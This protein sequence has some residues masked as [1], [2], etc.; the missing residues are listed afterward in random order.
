M[1]ES[2][3]D[4]PGRDTLYAIADYFNVSVDYILHGGDAT[5]QPPRTAEVVED[6][7]ELALL[8]F[9]RG[10]DESERMLMVKM[11]AIPPRRR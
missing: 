3:K 6:P 10:L 2:G 7:D 9:W 8:G 11:L 4:L 1:I 5:P